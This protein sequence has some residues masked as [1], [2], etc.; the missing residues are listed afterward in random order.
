MY[1]CMYV[2]IYVLTF[3]SVH[4]PTKPN[5][6][7]THIHMHLLHLHKF[8]LQTTDKNLQTTNVQM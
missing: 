3:Q 6:V 7:P 1:V 2:R 5:T 4:F 8:K